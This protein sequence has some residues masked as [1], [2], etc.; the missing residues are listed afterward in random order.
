MLVEREDAARI[1]RFLDL[2]APSQPADLAFVFGTRSL[3]PIEIAADLFRRGLAWYVVLTGGSRS[4]LGGLIEALA[5]QKALLERGVP[6][7]HIILESESAN[8]LEN[9]VFA[10]PKIAAKINIDSVTAVIAVAK[11]YHSRRCLMTLKPHLPEGV[12]YYVASYEPEGRSR[13]DW[14]MHEDGAMRVLHEWRCI[15]KYLAQG[16]MAEVWEQDGA[17]V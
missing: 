5:H 11:W 6:E 15:P 1:A 17:Y 16:H 4:D 7:D 14:Y 2:H 8:T 3:L 10:L 12:R 9:V 13:S